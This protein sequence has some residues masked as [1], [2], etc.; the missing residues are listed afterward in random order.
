MSAD[1][2]S[3]LIAGERQAMVPPAAA[4][5]ATWAKVASSVRAPGAVVPADGGATGAAASATPWAKIV[6]VFALGGGGVAYATSDDAVTPP[7]VTATS[8][9]TAAAP[10]RRTSQDKGSV[11][12]PV[13]TNEA[14]PT[15]LPPSIVPTEVIPTGA[16]VASVAARLSADSNGHE[17]QTKVAAPAEAELSP[18]SALGEEA[19]LLGAA[20]RALRAADHDAALG[21]LAAHAQ[22]FPQGQ[23]AEDSLALRARTLCDRGDHVQGAAAAKQLAHAFPASKHL[24]RVGRVCAASDAQ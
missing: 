9:H 23:L 1:K 17:P 13:V 20:G 6:L 3:D 7:S 12:S 24:A 2:L 14:S 15:P 11:S 5:E 18:A 10:P 16:G 19:R 22:R 21:H 8:T 4:Q